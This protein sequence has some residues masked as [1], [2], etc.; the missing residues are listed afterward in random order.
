MNSQQ[1]SVQSVV[2]DSFQDATGA[3]ALTEASSFVKTQMYWHCKHL[4]ASEDGIH[5]RDDGLLVPDSFY[6]PD[7]DL[8]STGPGH[9]DHFV[10]WREIVEDYSN[11]H[12]TFQTDKL[13]AL[14]GIAT[15][16]PS[17]HEDELLGGIWRNDLPGGLLWVTWDPFNSEPTALEGVPSWPWASIRGSI[18][19]SYSKIDEVCL[20]V[21]EASRDTLTL[22]A[23]LWPCK[24]F[25]LVSGYTLFSRDGHPALQYV[26]VSSSP[27]T[28]L[29][30]RGATTPMVLDFAKA[31]QLHKSALYLLPITVGR[32]DCSFSGL[33]VTPLHAGSD[34]FRRAGLFCDNFVGSLGDGSAHEEEADPIRR[35]F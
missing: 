25:N 28:Q 8:N 26:H 14:Q 10:K 2:S 32:S 7:N 35:Q 12:L 19:Y 27:D 9:L 29:S 6:G 33:V 15:V 18:K 23:M 31:G 22:E 34:R 11:R 4:A 21:V 24:Q 30:L 16:F 1:Q 13:I 3:H 17:A 5:H 20:N